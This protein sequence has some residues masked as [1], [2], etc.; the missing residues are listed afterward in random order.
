MVYFY[1]LVGKMQVT[2]DLIAFLL[3]ESTTYQANLDCIKLFWQLDPW[4][5]C[6]QHSLFTGTTVCPCNEDNGSNDLFQLINFYLLNWSFWAYHGLVLAL[7]CEILQPA[8]S[9]WV[10][11]LAPHL[12]I[13]YASFPQ[14]LTKVCQFCILHTSSSRP[15]GCPHCFPL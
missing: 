6:F 15:P 11:L 8:W 14:F 5:Q 7:F 9:Q 12:D 4:M 10:D 13:L 1:C 3:A 2:S